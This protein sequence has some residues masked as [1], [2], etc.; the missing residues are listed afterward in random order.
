MGMKVVECEFDMIQQFNPFT[1]VMKKGNEILYFFP[2]TK[3]FL[4]RKM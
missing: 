1:W 2:E 4:K 3:E